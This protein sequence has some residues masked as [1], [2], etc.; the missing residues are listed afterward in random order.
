[1]FKALI[2]L[3]RK[4]IV[5]SLA[6]KECILSYGKNILKRSI[7]FVFLIILVVIGCSRR[8]EI[9]QQEKVLIRWAGYTSV[10]YNPFRIKKSREFEKLY[11]HVRV[12]YEPVGGHYAGKILTQIAGKVAPDIFFVDDLHLYVQ[13]GALVDLTEKVEA[14]KEFFNEIN[15]KLIDA[16]R[17]KGKIY[18]LPGNY[19]LRGILFYN[20]KIFDEEGIDYPD[21]TWTWQDLLETAKRLT[22][23]DSDGR[24][25]R[26]GY[27]DQIAGGMLFYIYQ[28]GGRLWNEERSKCIINTLESQQAM[29]FWDSF[30]T[31]Y[32][33]SPP[34]SAYKE[35][36]TARDIFIMGRAA[37]YGGN[38][39]DIRV[40]KYHKKMKNYEVAFFPVPEKG[41]KRF[42]A[43]SC[44]SFGIWSGSKHP[45]IAYEFA[46]FMITPGWIKTLVEL[47]D[48]LPLRKEGEAMEAFLNLPGVSQNTKEVLLDT[49]EISQ[50]WNQ[51]LYHPNLSHMELNHLIAQEMDKFN[52]G[53]SSAEE[54]L[55]EIQN[56]LNKRISGD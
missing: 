8:E 29:N 2:I 43:W 32:H 15:P 20:K 44:I 38:S 52:L 5:G 11:P 37:M 3:W 18:A 45:E 6:P 39:W 17:W 28:N 22:K 4:R 35:M 23:K 36:Q 30:H 46:K 13:K 26:F 9:D 33:V 16:H 12:R 1:M 14:D 51:L 27:V 21:E 7:I 56:K 31:K 19:G 41:K 49:A 53:L 34:P 24:I 42:A 25:V 48:S 55:R 50:N 47:S 54:T 40:F 10:D